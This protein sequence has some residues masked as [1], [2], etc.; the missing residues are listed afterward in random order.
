MTLRLV[1]TFMFA[2]A[3]PATVLSQQSQDAKSVAD[4]A[5]ASGPTTVCVGLNQTDLRGQ[6]ECEKRD[7]AR[8]F[9]VA[10]KPEAALRLLCATTEARAAFGDDK[11]GVPDKCLQSV[12]IKKP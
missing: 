12:G 6:V 5:V 4:A 9:L 2:F 7:T 8:L 3:L 1:A 11:N 10:G